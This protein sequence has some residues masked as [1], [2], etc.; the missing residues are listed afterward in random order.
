[1]KRVNVHREMQPISHGLHRIT[2][3]LIGLVDALGVPV[4]PVQF[5]LKHGQSKRVRQA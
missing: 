3:E 2:M 1:M 4:R 5:I